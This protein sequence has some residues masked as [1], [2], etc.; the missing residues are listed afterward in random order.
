MI[1]E[2]FLTYVAG[3]AAA[4]RAE[5]TSALARAYLYSDLD[6]DERAAA[7]AALTEMLDDPSPLPRRA[8][9]EAFAATRAAPRHCVLTLARDQ[10]DI[11]ALVLARSPLLADGELIEF[12][13]IGDVFAQ[14]AVALRHGLSAL[15]CAALADFASREA[16]V[17]LAVNTSAMAD[18]T[19]LRRVLERFGD[20]GEIREAIL[21]R[22]DISAGLRA[23]LVVATADALTRFSIATG[24]LGP[25]RAARVAREAIER[26]AVTIAADP[27]EGGPWPALAVTRRLR[28]HGRLT[29]AL[30][31]RA[32]VSGDA[33]LFQAMLAELSGRGL[34]QVAGHCRRPDGAGFAAI[35][36]KAKLPAGLLP[37]FRGALAA[38]LGAGGAADGDTGVRRDLVRAAQAA[39]RREGAFA[40]GV[41]AALASLEA[42]AMREEARRAR[43][44]R[45]APPALRDAGPRDTS[46]SAIRIDLAAIGAELAA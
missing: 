38:L 28:L 21:S 36:A 1:V 9:A 33:S 26:S 24:W 20:D 2:R 10:S 35:Y 40:P 16:L 8:L 3:A 32:L 17:S 34:D 7:E 11:A 13:R 6:A 14:A 23:D 45:I 41:E 5:A 31:L 29:P 18:E 22:G 42:E 30:A 15:V 27:D 25:E 12:A 43:A 19:V 39:C 44:I 4:G 37:A 46:V